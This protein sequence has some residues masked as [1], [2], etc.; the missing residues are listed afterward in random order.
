M[1]MCY[2]ASC[3]ASCADSCVNASQINCS[4]DCCNS[5]GCLN[6]SFA[7]MM[8]MM[9]TPVIPTTA[10]TTPVPTMTTTT[11]ATPANVNKCRTGTCTGEKCY[12]SFSNS[13]ACSSSQRHCQLKK[14]S[15]N[16]NLQWTAGCTTNCS[17][18]PQCKSTTVPPCHLECCNATTTSC[19]WLNGT[20]NVPSFATRGPRL[21]T[22]LIVS[23]L[24]LIAISFLL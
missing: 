13:Q 23:I 24:S 10:I 8:M 6:D 4:I 7:S 3:S 2:T 5:T 15:V 18:K 20:L 16:S 19:L 1:E 22:E 21:H 17:G 12:T 11:P 14:E 9:T